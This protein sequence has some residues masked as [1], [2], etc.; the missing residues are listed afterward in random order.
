MLH[1]KFFL[2]RFIIFF[3][4]FRL[5]DDRCVVNPEAGNLCNPPQ[6]FRGKFTI[7]Y[8]YDSQFSLRLFLL[9]SWISFYSFSK[10]RLLVQDMSNE[11]LLLSKTILESSKAG[12]EWG[13]N[14]R[15]NAIKTIAC[16][17]VRMCTTWF[18]NFNVR[19]WNFVACCRN[20]EKAEW[21][22]KQEG[23]GDLS[24]LW[25]CCTG[26]RW[27]LK[28]ELDISVMFSLLWK[29]IWNVCFHLF[30]L[31]TFMWDSPKRKNSLDCFDI[32]RRIFFLRIVWNL[33]QTL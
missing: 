8:D 26:K 7:K 21:N 4:C 25:K 17:S 18:R 9:L 12:F 30:W 29:L 28:E 24:A 13:W 1:Y 32:F 33:F 15:C 5:V 14:H 19:Y 20:W 3:S 10:N 11:S 6:K 31:L 22:G 23:D 27:S 2:P 16:E